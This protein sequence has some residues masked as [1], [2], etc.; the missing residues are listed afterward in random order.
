MDRARNFLQRFT[1][2]QIK[3]LNG[4]KKPFKI[5]FQFLFDGD[6]LVGGCKFE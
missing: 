6:T 2:Q 5:V 3:T 1:Q 4:P